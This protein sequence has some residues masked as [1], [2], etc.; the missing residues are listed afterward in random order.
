LQEL[1]SRVDPG[2]VLPCACGR[3]HH[4]A[5]A[6]V[7]VDSGALER[8]AEL[9]HRRHGV[10]PALW[11]LSDEN[12]EAAA[13]ARWK[14]L[15]GGAVS[16]RILPAAPRPV[17]SLELVGELAADVRAARP[18]VLVAVG[19]GVMSDLVKRVSLDVGLPSWCIAT[20]PSV[21]AYSSATASLRIA[22]L[23]TAGPA[24]PSEV[25]VCDLDVLG[26]APP[27]L[28][29]GGIGDLLAKIVA[30][31]DWNV[32]RLVTGEHYCAVIAELALSAARRAIDAARELATDSVA[33]TASLTDAILVSGFAMQ[34]FGT[35]RPAASAEHTIA[36][37]WETTAAAR[38]EYQLHGLLVGAAT[39]LVARGYS[40]FHGRLEEIDVDVDER[41]AAWAAL[42]P[43]HQRLEE[44]LQPYAG[45]IAAEIAP[46]IDGAV[47]AARL[48]AFA[49]ERESIAELAGP[50]LTELSGALDLVGRLGLPLSL[51]AVGIAE[52]LRMLPVRNARLLRA[53][54][55]TFDLAHELGREAELFAAIA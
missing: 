49:R 5:T 28:V 1:L 40:A 24:R 42:P 4:I 47:L 33:A 12:T 2:G 35:S 31:F 30:Y 41:V 6:E 23:H 14:S 53:R 27:L 3:E 37:F 11:V 18:D 50:L 9:L 36:H 32:A 29:L 8:S 20:A 44:G 39:A 16:A 54:Y 17:P 38:P 19:A 15:A 43:W 25:I 26:R 10:R 21:D 52:P 22:G 46:P 45:K 34:A 7:L 13:G 51:D 55:T 48:G